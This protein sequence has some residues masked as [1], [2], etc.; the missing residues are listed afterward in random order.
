MPKTIKLEPHLGP[1]GLENRCRVRPGIR[2]LGATLPDHLPVLGQG[3]T[4]AE[5]N[6]EL[7]TGCSRGRILRLDPPLNN[8][9]RPRGFGVV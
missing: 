5:V 7:T 2:S 1:E 6:V 4:T 9:P 8:R 3:E